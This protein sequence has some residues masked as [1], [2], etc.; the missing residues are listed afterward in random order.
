[1][2]EE[3]ARVNRARGEVGGRAASDVPS[4]D[5]KGLLR[6]KGSPEL[7]SESIPSG[8]SWTMSVR[9]NR[10]SFSQE[11]LKVK[12]IIPVGGHGICRREDKRIG[13]VSDASV[14][15]PS[16]RAAEASESSRTDTGHSSCA[17]EADGEEC[18]RMR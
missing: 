2:G 15:S 7:L 17:F 8:S 1:M 12:Q 13:F 9:L 10:I 6:Q 3:A 16:H 11:L 14:A 5:V 18:S 4:G